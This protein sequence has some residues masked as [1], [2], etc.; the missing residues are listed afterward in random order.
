M[1]IELLSIEMHHRD[2]DESAAEHAIE[3]SGAE[4]GPSAWRV[5]QSRREREK[6]SV[7]VTP[8]CTPVYICALSFVK[9]KT[10]D[11]GC[12]QVCMCTYIVPCTRTMYIVPCT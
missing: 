11:R 6:V 4:S 10:L 9:R 3:E 12:V 5:Q 2:A 7:C 1:Y 8:K